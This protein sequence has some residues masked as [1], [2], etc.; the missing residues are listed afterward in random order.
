MVTYNICY[1]IVAL[2][3]LLLIIL[4]YFMKRGIPSYQNRVFLLLLFTA[5]TAS[6][7]DIADVLFINAGSLIPNWMKYISSGGCFVLQVLIALQVFYYVLGITTTW[8]ETKLFVKLATCIPYFIMLGLTFTTY[9]THLI[10]YY[11]QQGNY[12]RGNGR[13]IAIL[14]GI[15]YLFLAAG[16]I[17]RLKSS[18]SRETRITLWIVTAIGTIGVVAQT[19]V[20]GLITQMFGV[21]LCLLITFFTLQN[22][23]MAMD[24][25][26]RVYNRSTFVTMTSFDFAARKHFSVVV[27]MLEDISFLQRNLGMEHVRVLQRSVVEKLRE[28]DKE[29]LIYH[30]NDS[31]FC[32]VF[33]SLYGRKLDGI[34]EHMS[35][36]FEKPWMIN[37][38]STLL[39]AHLCR[40]ECPEDVTEV[41]GILD[42]ISYLGEEALGDRIVSLH[43]LNIHERNRTKEREQLIRDAVEYSKF[44]VCCRK[45]YSLSKN[46]VVGAEIALCVIGEDG[47]IYSD[48]CKELLERTGLS[49]RVS[50]YLFRAACDYLVSKRNAGEQ[51]ESVEVGIS[52]FMCMHQ[53]F[54]DEIKWLMKE[55]KISP[56][57]IRLK[58]TESEAQDSSRQLQE[59]MKK[60][61]DAGVWFSLDGYGAGYTN[62]AYIYEL[63][64]SHVEMSREVYAAAM[65]DEQAMS[66]LKNTIHMLHELDMQVTICG[67]RTGM[68]E[69]VLRDIQCDFV[70]GTYQPL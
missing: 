28:T 18:F 17:W 57:A 31:C 25:Y 54:L 51:V 32:L 33:N 61:S 14:L 55:Y 4:L 43:D 49:F 22:P 68:N 1:D 42:V 48:D 35:E 23:F 59:M 39:S 11:D 20:P 69:K 46:Q 29:V 47:L 30:I 21:A 44:D 34:M 70:I 53:K 38:I 9:Y 15:F 40:I 45:L 62:I 16:R 65:S 3:L 7:F 56:G 63:P 8:K 5:L 13:M 2:V 60:F 52:I 6:I 12:I 67:T 19:L 50:I 64:V 37:G 26:L 58:I 27:V 10:F 36:Q 66:I 24:G 41:N